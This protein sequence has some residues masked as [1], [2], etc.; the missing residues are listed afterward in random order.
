MVTTI[1]M[2]QIPSSTEHHLGALPSCPHGHPTAVP[3]L[4][5]AAALQGLQEDEATVPISFPASGWGLLLGGHHLQGCS[6]HGLE[7]KGGAQL[8]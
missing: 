4:P 6:I 8:G 5:G 2:D 7:G 3:H 1:P